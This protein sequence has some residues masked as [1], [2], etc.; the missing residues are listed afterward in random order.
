MKLRLK[1]TFPEGTYSL[2]SEKLGSVSFFL[3]DDSVDLQKVPFYRRRATRKTIEKD[4]LLNGVRERVAQLTQREPLSAYFTL[5]SNNPEIYVKE[6]PEVGIGPS[7]TVE[8]LIVHTQYEAIRALEHELNV[9]PLPGSGDIATYKK[10]LVTGTV[11]HIA[12]TPYRIT[13]F[14][15]FDTIECPNP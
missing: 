1:V 15:V 4:R 9:Y 13:L 2:H 6:H 10:I 12:E 5:Y 14:F 11:Y 3:E 7:R 8:V